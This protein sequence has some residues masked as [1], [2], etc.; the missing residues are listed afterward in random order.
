[1]DVVGMA[2]DVHAADDKIE[3]IKEELEIEAALA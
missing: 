2:I 1:M 3:Y